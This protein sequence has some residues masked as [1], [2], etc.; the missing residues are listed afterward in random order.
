MSERT[1]PARTRGV[2]WHE[3][4]AGDPVDS[5]MG[6]WAHITTRFPEG[7]SGSRLSTQDPAIQ[8]ETARFWFLLNYEPYRLP[9]GRYFGFAESTPTQPTEFAPDVDTSSADAPPMASAPVDG[10]RTHGYGRGG[11]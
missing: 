2:L 4:S 5:P 11:Y 8:L 1:V 9:P 3:F 10:E 6:E 7:I